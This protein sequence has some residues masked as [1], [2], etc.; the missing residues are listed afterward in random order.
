M[1]GQSSNALLSD[2][3]IK[4]WRWVQ[5][6]CRPGGQTE[7]S[8]TLVATMRD[9]GIS[10]LHTPHLT[11]CL[12]HS[13]FHFQHLG[14]TFVYHCAHCLLSVPHSTHLISVVWF[15]Y[16][17]GNAHCTQE[18]LQ[19]QCN[20]NQPLQYTREGWYSFTT[21]KLALAMLQYHV[22]NKL[23]VGVSPPSAGT[24]ASHPCPL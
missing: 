3:N 4:S 24:L 7:T 15:V 20:V 14:F 6:D 13:A 11:C 17:S 22:Q 23:W 5:V 10:L 21:S 18:A 8:S 12:Q 19:K 1:S 9:T 16:C 2:N